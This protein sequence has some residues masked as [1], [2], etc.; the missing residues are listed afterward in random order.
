M[1]TESGRGYRDFTG[2]SLYLVGE[3]DAMLQ[4]RSAVLVPLT[5]LV[6]PMVGF[7]SF[8]KFSEHSTHFRHSDAFIV[9]VDFSLQ[10]ST[11][12]N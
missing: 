8:A 2:R 5:T 9:P 12:T 1:T 10:K 6:F 7:G 11:V 4:P 3:A